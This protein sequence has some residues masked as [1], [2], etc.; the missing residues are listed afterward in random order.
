MATATPTTQATAE[1]TATAPIARMVLAQVRAVMIYYRRM[2]QFLF[3]SAALPI[4]FYI[5]FGLSA[6][7]RLPNGAA[8]GTLVMV[9]MGAYSVSSVL[10]FNIGIGQATALQTNFVEGAHPGGVALHHREG[11]H[12]ALDAAHATHHRQGADVHKLVDAEY[13]TDHGTVADHHV[14]CHRHP[15]GDHNPIS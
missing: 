5:M 1:H 8:V 7:E 15:I 14:A 10:V 6:V 4:F 11:G 3:F 9:H 13:T 12:I 2:P